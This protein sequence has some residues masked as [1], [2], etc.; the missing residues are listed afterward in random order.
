MEVFWEVVY[1]LGGRAGHA[2][3]RF[4]FRAALEAV[5]QAAPIFCGSTGSFLAALTAPA[6]K[7]FLLLTEAYPSLFPFIGLR[8]RSSG[9]IPHIF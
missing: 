6:A 8:G 5:F 9:W 1:V 3:V 2:G 4:R 7:D